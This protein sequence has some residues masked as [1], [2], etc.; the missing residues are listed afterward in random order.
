MIKREKAV[1][2]MANKA[3]TDLSDKEGYICEFDSGVKVSGGTNVLGVIV[4]GGETESDVAIIGTFDGIVTGKASATVT[5]GSKVVVDSNGKIKDLPATTGT[6]KVI[7]VA[8]EGG[9]ADELVPFAPM[10]VQSVTIS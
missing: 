3:S 6:Y 2:R 7:G 8:V 10:L 1:V 9:A 5:K 4:E